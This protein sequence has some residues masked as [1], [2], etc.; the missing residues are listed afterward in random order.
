MKRK[1]T[2]ET[3]P[4]LALAALTGF[5]V[6][7]TAKEF[8][9][10]VNV[11]RRAFVDQGKLVYHL[12]QLKL[13]PGQSVYN[14]LQGQGVPEG[15]V[16]QAVATADIIEKLVIPGHLPEAR[17]DEVITFRIGRQARRLL[18]GKGESKLILAPEAVATLLATGE[19]AAIGAELDCLCEHGM[20]IAERETQLADK[21]AE[22]ERLKAAAAEAEKIKAADEARK[23]AEAEA[24]KTK[25]AADAL[26]NNGRE[27]K[28][29]DP[30]ETVTAET[31]EIS[32]NPETEAPVQT[33]APAP[34]E[35]T[36]PDSP[37]TPPVEIPDETP[38]P[39]ETD[40]EEE[41]A[42][43]DEQADEEEEEEEAEDEDDAPEPVVVDGRDNN[44]PPA[45]PA[46][47]LTDITARMDDAL[48]DAMNLGADDMKALL[49]FMQSA[50]E[51]IATVLDS[52]AVPVAA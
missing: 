52:M 32:A 28:L 33:P 36:A 24:A 29:P 38:A 45:P 30:S 37:D 11:R 19:S 4:V 31:T 12:R 40:D 2:T 51:S 25:A 9:E 34:T 42:D 43:E 49:I 3:V 44:P 46:P 5:T 35:T 39:S 17:F 15:S 26:L 13:K 1:T 21:A 41:E 47:T 18:T 7:Q 23:L 16:Q 20:T 8:K 14:I 6:T 22:A 10:R 48:T 50:T 27:G